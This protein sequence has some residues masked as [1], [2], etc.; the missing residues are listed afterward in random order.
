MSNPQQRKFA[1]VRKAEPR[2]SCWGQYGTRG[3]CVNCKAH[4]NTCRRNSPGGGD[5]ER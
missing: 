2:P 1:V 3:K 5:D 4:K